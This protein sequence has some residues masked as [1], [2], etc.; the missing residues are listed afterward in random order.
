MLGYDTVFIN[1]I[2]DGELVRMALR[3]SRIILTKDTGILKRRI[4]ANGTVK[5]IWIQSCKIREQLA[6]VADELDLLSGADPFTR[7][8]ECN[9]PLVPKPK[10]EIAHLIP[11]YVSQTQQSFTQCSA[12]GRVYWRGT[13]WQ[14]MNE[15]FQQLTGVSS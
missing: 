9:L 6:Q 3:E 1:D 4:V 7:C 5:A 10:E 2:E 8:L 11:P 12:C 14:K 13:H 15:E